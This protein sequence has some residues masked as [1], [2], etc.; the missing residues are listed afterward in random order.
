[1][2]DVVYYNTVMHYHN[3]KH[4]YHYYHVESRL[5]SCALSFINIVKIQAIE[6][7]NESD[8]EDKITIA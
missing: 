6:C 5:A 2:R 1:M 7:L 3:S 4:I 8:K